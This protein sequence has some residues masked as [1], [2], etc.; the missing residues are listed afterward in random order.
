V[1]SA[2]H[3]LPDE[4]ADHVVV[5][6]G[7]YVVHDPLGE[8]VGSLPWDRIIDGMI[9]QPTR[10]AVKVLSPHGSGYGVVPA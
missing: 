7:Y 6:R 2:R 3:Q 9:V 10:R 1:C 4:D 8:F 5:A